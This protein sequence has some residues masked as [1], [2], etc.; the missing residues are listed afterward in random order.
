M[1]PA[2]RATDSV[3]TA[4]EGGVVR[5][6]IVH[7]GVLTSAAAPTPPAGARTFVTPRC[8]LRPG[9]P[10][11]LCQ[12]DVTGPQDCG[13]VYLVMTDD[14]LRRGVRGQSARV[15]KTLCGSSR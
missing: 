15:M 9:Q 2:E 10:C 11:T 3:V 4:E 6:T 13:L 12:I 8:P 14:E 7:D 1:A 5:P